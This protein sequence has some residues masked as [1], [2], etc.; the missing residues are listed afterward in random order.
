MDDYAAG[1]RVVERY[2]HHIGEA[3]AKLEQLRTVHAI[4][5]FLDQADADWAARRR[6]GWT[7][8]RCARLRLRVAA[9]KSAPHWPDLVRRGL[10][11]RDRATFYRADAAAR[12]LGIDIWEHHFARLESGEDDGWYDVMQTDDAA[13]IDRVIALAEKRL[14]LEQIATG[15]AEELGL[16]RAW[17]SHGALDFVVQDLGPFPGRGWPLLRAALRSPVTRNRNMALRTLASWGRAAWPP[18]ARSLLQAASR[19]EPGADVRERIDAVLAGRPLD[20]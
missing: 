5:R 3:P 16:G 20:D 11:A 4:T 13:R 9:V 6:R 18:E 10:A 15:P 7:P 12:A 8:G 17:A 19:D 14:P 1:A 2:L